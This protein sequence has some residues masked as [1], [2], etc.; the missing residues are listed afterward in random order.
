[1]VST[2]ALMLRRPGEKRGE[3]QET[4]SLGRCCDAQ[5]H[6][7]DANLLALVWIWRVPSHGDPGRAGTAGL[8]NRPGQRPGWRRPCRGESMG[9]AGSQG[10]V[11]ESKASFRATGGWP[12]LEPGAEGREGPLGDMA[13]W[14]GQ[15][16][17]A[18]AGAEGP[19][20]GPRPP[21][22]RAPGALGRTW[23]ASRGCLDLTRRWASAR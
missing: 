3:H 4:Q 14:H 8:W 13:P 20:R 1:M 9:W 10:A 16:C 7:H 6:G 2:P 12:A 22:H 5:V 15:A 17:V 23:A 19:W 11:Q 21:R 18:E